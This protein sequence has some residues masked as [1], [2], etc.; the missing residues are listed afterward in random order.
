VKHA[1]KAALNLRDI[2]LAIVGVGLLVALILAA[3][4]QQALRLI[5]HFHP[6]ALI[7]FFLLMAGYEVV[8]CAQWHYMLTKLNIVVPLR[9]QIFAY[10]IGE[11]TKNLPIGNF[12]PDYILTREGGA[13]FGR[14]SSSSLLISV[15]EVA[16]ALTGIVIIG[17]DGW[18]W[19]RPLI[20]IGT[21]L[22][23]LLAWAVYRWYHHSP[24]TGH[25]A[26]T[27]QSQH[28]GQHEPPAWAS[29]VLRWKWVCRAMDEL[30]QF[31]QGEA[32][33]LHPDV[34]AVSTVACAVYMVFSGLAL[35]AV[36]LGLGLSGIT[37]EA[38]LAASFFSLA[39]STIIPVPTDLGTSEASGSG[40]LVAVG[41]SVTGAVST[42]LLYRFLNLVEQILVAILACV[43]FPA[44]F[45]A[46]W[47]ARPKE[48]KE[49][50]SPQP[51]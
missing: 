22:F 46:M 25:T 48:E 20:L 15:L 40:A 18:T 28:G 24:R 19:I 30:R 42:L 1:L 41:L 49:E 9:T 32:I 7:A 47:H 26:H 39:V 36:I 51:T 5:T 45:R 43:A 44:E 38:A 2:M 23:V 10:A 34:I 4:P 33:L 37:W 50:V 6:G 14:A 13:D 3:G 31:T 21:F 8:R 29:G 35:Y 17:I 12:V 11:F 27:G 16:V